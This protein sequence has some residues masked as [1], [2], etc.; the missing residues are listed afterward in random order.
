MRQVIEPFYMKEP[1]HLDPT[2]KGIDN[3]ILTSG[4]ELLDEYGDCQKVIRI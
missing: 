4:L 1:N 2:T 3:I